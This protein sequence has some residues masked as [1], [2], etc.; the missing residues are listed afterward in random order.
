MKRILFCL[1]CLLVI[2]KIVYKP[3]ADWQG[4]LASSDPVQTSGSLPT[5]WTLNDFTVTPKARYHIRAVVLSKKH[6]WAGERED[7]ISPYDLALGWGMMSEARVIN[8][9][10]LSHGWRWYNYTWGPNPGFDVNKIS[11]YSANNHIIPADKDILKQIKKI[12]RFDRVDLEGYLVDINASDG[13]HWN[14]SLSRT[15]NAGGSCE[16]F[17]V[18]K[19]Q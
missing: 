19:V 10:K 15:D 11:R 8:A 17:W 1:I 4:Q 18:N 5:P 9:I 14:T 12:K 3:K 2:W 6:Y 7:K 16:V 13:W